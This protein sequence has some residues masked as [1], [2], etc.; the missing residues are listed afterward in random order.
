MMITL[1]DM[2]VNSDLIIKVFYYVK[3]YTYNIHPIPEI[4]LIILSDVLTYIT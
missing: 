2:V 1:D 3:A 4:Q